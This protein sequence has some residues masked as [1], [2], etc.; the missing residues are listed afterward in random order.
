MATLADESDDAEI[1]TP[2]STASTDSYEEGKKYYIAVSTNKQDD[3]TYT[4]NYSNSIWF[5]YKDGTL[6]FGG[7][8]EMPDYSLSAGTLLSDGLYGFHFANPQWQQWKKQINKVV[9]G[10]DITYVGQYNIQGTEATTVIFECPTI[11]S[12]HLCSTFNNKMSHYK[13]LHFW[14]ILLSF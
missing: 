14:N 9:V 13:I 3:D 4:I 6:T 11:K 10:K 12:T 8:G 5:M 2:D 1:I 7:S